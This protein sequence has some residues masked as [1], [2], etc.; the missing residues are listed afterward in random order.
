M[1]K[2]DQITEY[3]QN[4][5]VQDTTVPRN[6]RRAASD[7]IKFLKEKDKENKVKAYSAI[8]VLD[9]VS[10]DPNMPMHARTIIWEV[11]SELEKVE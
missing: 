6:I 5:I 9:G 11:L 1:S 3:L 7:A 4:Y 10:N 8:E 2:V